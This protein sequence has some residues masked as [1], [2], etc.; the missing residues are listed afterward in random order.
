ML[1]SYLED[2]RAVRN[3]KTQL[4]QSGVPKAEIKKI[5]RLVKNE[6]TLN[7]RIERLHLMQSLFKYWHVAHLPFAL[8]MLVIVLVH[9]VITVGL[10]YTWIF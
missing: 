9:V 2:N 8:I 6:Q 10:G 7:R 3:L 5:I 1:K 4:K